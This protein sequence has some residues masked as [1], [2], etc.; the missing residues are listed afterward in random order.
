M[1]IISRFSRYTKQPYTVFA[2]VDRSLFVTR[3]LGLLLPNLAN[4]LS[5]IM[6]APKRYLNKLLF[7]LNDKKR[8]G[9]VRAICRPLSTI[10]LPNS[11]SYPFLNNLVSKSTRFLLKSSV[12]TF[13][14]P[15]IEQNIFMA[16][17]QGLQMNLLICYQSIFN[18]ELPFKNNIR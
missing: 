17:G 1:P 5:E 13:P 6:K 4:S 18:S 11:G 3:A 8:Y 7:L 14:F 10:Q 2:C 12:Y 16:F 9:S 15:W